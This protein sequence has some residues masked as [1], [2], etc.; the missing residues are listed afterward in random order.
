MTFNQVLK[1]LKS[2]SNPAAVRG[3]ARFGITAA[4]A[5]GWSTPA[6]KT[7]ARQIGK[8]HDLAQRL[9]STGILEAR[10]LAGLIA[11]K[12]KVTERQMEAWVED[13]DSWAVCDGT[14]LNLFRYTPF[15]Y[16]K[17][18]EWS[19]R[20]EEF[21]KRA[22]F[23]LMACLAV[24]NKAANDRMFL[25]FLPLI[26]RQASDERNYV[27]KAV[28]WALRQIG[29]RNQRLNRAAIKAAQEIHR[30]NSSSA[31]WIAS[32]ALRELRSGAV[33]GRLRLKGAV[34]PAT[35]GIHSSSLQK[36]ARFRGNDRIAI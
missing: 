7:F 1:R 31:R 22:G 30:L 33:Q 15:A 29:K 12:E 21:V 3:M 13:F 28:N 8:D 36:Q 35:A 5:Y 23:A 10:A 26:K 11:E 20:Q 16:K 18:R 19:E 14:C 9:W 6:L 25:H 27:K 4:K 2:K 32:D 24:G 34:I 17:C